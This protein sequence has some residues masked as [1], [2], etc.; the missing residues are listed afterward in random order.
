MEFVGKGYTSTKLG[1]LS[2]MSEITSLLMEYQQGPARLVARNITE[3]LSALKEIALAQGKPV[4]DLD[5][6]E[7]GSGQKSIHL[8]V[9]SQGNR[10]IGIDRESTGDDLS[11]QG[12]LQT[13]KTDGAIRALKTV[14]RKTLG[15]DRGLK[16]ELARQMG[17]EAWPSLN[18]KNMDAERMTFP[19]ASFDVIFS[20]AVFEHLVNPADVLREVTRVI[21]PGGIF[22]CLL[23]LYT[24]Y[25]GCHDLRVF[26]NRRGDIPL[27]A[28]LRET[29][30]HKV[31]QNTYL[32]CLRLAEWRSIFSDAL[33][34]VRIDALMD[35]SDPNHLS[36]L[37]KLRGSG[38]LSDYSDE[39][40]LTV[41][42]RA[43]WKNSD[44]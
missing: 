8:A 24:S 22:Y 37:A 35:D 33:S 25:S 10:A 21:R 42:L 38:E 11:V 19:S 23:H 36:E 15:F 16:K 7:I 43:V 26:A 30:R 1:I 20:R 39:E 6:L 29:H 32:N 9:M 4:M 31:I 28:H 13:I 18:L 12:I 44:Q 5:I 40:L 34:G 14:G 3:T 2:R 27:W 41:T 17:L